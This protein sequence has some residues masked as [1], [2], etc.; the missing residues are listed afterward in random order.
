MNT[1][2]QMHLY[3]IKNIKWNKRDSFQVLV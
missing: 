2:I 3:L 1:S